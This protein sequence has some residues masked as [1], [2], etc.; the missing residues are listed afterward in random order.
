MALA[1][2]TL[3]AACGD[4]GEGTG[5]EAPSAG[6]FDGRAWN[7]DDLSGSI[8][9]VG[10]GGTFSEAEFEFVWDP[11]TEITGVE[12][13][14]IPWSTDI[15]NR[16]ES[17]VAAGRVDIDQF[18]VTAGNYEQFAD[19]CLEDIDYSLFPQAVL[20]TMD[21]QYKLP[22][23]V[24]YAEASIVLAYST[25]AFPD[26]DSQPKTWADFWDV[27]RFPGKRSMQNFEPVKV[28][29]AA[30][31]ADGV[32]PDQMYPIDWDRA[33]AKLE[34][35]K[36]HVVKWWGSGTEAQQLV[37]TGEATMV[38]MSNARVEDLIDQ[39]APVAYTLNEALAHVDFLAVPKG[40]PNAAAS[41]ASI[42]FRFEESIGARI[43]E[44]WRQPIPSTAIYDAADKALADSWTTSTNDVPELGGVPNDITFRIDSFYWYETYPGTDRSNYDVINERFQSFIAS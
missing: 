28:I 9:N 31:L 24:G 2:V 7:T 20:D 17:Q 30:L 15:Y 35:I 19:C 36:P 3:I 4:G 43:G 42:A 13:V 33:F 27:E 5:T 44:A 16:I 21:E 37:A 11:F 25:D 18:S 1:A 38:A 14:E 6:E 40:A 41:M 22:K 29:E 32:A 23:A 8:T 10:F 39:E 34:E 26:A 12:V